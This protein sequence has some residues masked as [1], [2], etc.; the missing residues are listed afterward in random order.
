MELKQ[1]LG[2]QRLTAVLELLTDEQQAVVHDLL[3][4]IDDLEQICARQASMN[5]ELALA[6][7]DQS[8]A[9]LDHI[10]DAVKPKNTNTYGKMGRYTQ[11]RP[12]AVMLRGRL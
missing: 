12:E 10:Q 11:Q 1:S 9:L 5:A 6:L 2:G 8:Q 7:H 4:E 3:Q